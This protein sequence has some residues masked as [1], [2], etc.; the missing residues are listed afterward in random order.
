MQ[1]GGRESRDD[2][3]GGCSAGRGLLR[4]S[5]D[6]YAG[7]EG[8]IGRRCRDSKKRLKKRRQ[9]ENVAFFYHRGAA[10]EGK[11]EAKKLRMTS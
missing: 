7:Q 10:K 4:A 2:V 1:A 11:K 5:W 6:Y 3:S 9:C 8:A